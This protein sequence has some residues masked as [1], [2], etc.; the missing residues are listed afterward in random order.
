[1]EAVVVSRVLYV[2]YCSVPYTWLKYHTYRRDQ[3]MQWNNE[4]VRTS[5]K[6][7]PLWVHPRYGSAAVCALRVFWIWLRL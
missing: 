1:M 2:P 5:V 7:V 4:R 6:T 3:K